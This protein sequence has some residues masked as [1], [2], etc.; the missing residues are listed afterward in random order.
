MIFLIIISIPL[1]MSAVASKSKPVE[2]S[3]ATAEQIQKAKEALQREK[4][5]QMAEKKLAEEKHLT[6]EK[7]RQ[8]AE[9]R[10]K[11]L[12]VEEAKQ[13]WKDNLEGAKPPAPTKPYNLPSVGPETDEKEQQ[14]RGEGGNEMETR[15]NS[16][17]HRTQG[18]YKDNVNFSIPIGGDSDKRLINEIITKGSESTGINRKPLSS[19]VSNDS[20]KFRSYSRKYSSFGV[21]KQFN[22]LI[23]F[24]FS[25][26][27]ARERFFKK[28]D[29]SVVPAEKIV[30][31]LTDDEERYIYFNGFRNPELRAV[32]NDYVNRYGVI[33]YCYID[34]LFDYTF[35]DFTAEAIWAGMLKGIIEQYDIPS[36][37][38]IRNLFRRH[39]VVI[40]V[41][42]EE[43]KMDFKLLEFGLYLLSSSY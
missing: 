9:E 7:S 28:F 22:F 34:N 43:E 40:V 33:P 16:A 41:G 19:V 27:R 20:A 32:W 4:E 13:K 17:E 5:R 42:I 25:S 11:Q 23:D 24:I 36:K 1:T 39:K 26:N 18:R 31:L 8:E 10:K 38:E 37:E 2:V 35:P 3:L 6:E 21:E 14:V 29:I 30:N 12:A 15:K